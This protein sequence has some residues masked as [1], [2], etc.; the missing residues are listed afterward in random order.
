MKKLT[1]VK[2]QTDGNSPFGAKNQTD[3]QHGEVD[4]GSAA[5]PE[6][7]VGGGH[8]G[9]EA[10]RDDRRQTAPDG[11]HSLRTHQLPQTQGSHGQRELSSVLPA[12]GIK[13]DCDTEKIIVRNTRHFIT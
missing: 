11:Q 10:V 12:S 9:Q 2:T 13:D 3:L 7:H 8:Q 1:D 5:H 6:L 4:V